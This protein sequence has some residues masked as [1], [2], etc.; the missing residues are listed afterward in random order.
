MEPISAEALKRLRAVSSAT[1]S[2]LLFKRGLRNTWL[3]GVRRM[4]SAKGNMVGEA[5]TLRNIP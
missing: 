4:S 2:T 5:F 1:V 3:H